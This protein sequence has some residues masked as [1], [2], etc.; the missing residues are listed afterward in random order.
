MTQEMEELIQKL[1]DLTE[2][3]F[4][5]VEADLQTI[6]EQV[7][8]ETKGGTVYTVEGL[9][10]FRQLD[11]ELTFTPDEKLAT[12]IN[13]KYAGMEPI[14]IMAGFAQQEIDVEEQ[15]EQEPSDR[16]QVTELEPSEQDEEQAEPD[17]VEADATEKE[18]I[19]AEQLEQKQPEEKEK[20]VA[21][22]ED[23]SAQDKTPSTEKVKS[24]SESTEQQQKKEKKKEKAAA[25]TAKK[26]SKPKKK[27]KPGKKKPSKKANSHQDQ[28]TTWLII[29][30][31]AVLVLAVVIWGLSRRGAPEQDSSMATQQQTE[32][33][34]Q[35]S[36]EEQEP[37]TSKQDD[38]NRRST[39][40]AQATEVETAT[41]VTNNNIDTDLPEAPV[42]NVD[43]DTPYGLR[44]IPSNQ[45][46]T[47]YTLVVYSFGRESNAT[48]QADLLSNKGYRA[49]IDYV[50]L[51]DSTERW[52]VG[53]GQF[54]DIQAAKEA[55]KAIPEPHQSNYFIKRIN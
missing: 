18:E 11:G 16:A 2:M 53:I 49:I 44:G 24:E 29:S 6:V 32:A 21:S 47:G 55:A 54:E 31:A 42:L 15:I 39:S 19:T 35:A 3:A 34:E 17:Q 7:Q 30:A 50:T 4:E 10:T 9:G 28:T 13:Y 26:K 45:G 23:G 51:N 27:F 43:Y 8:T 37:T 41:K 36:V 5:D 1:A 14:E 25:T 52:R 46:M 22:K 38:A 48:Q 33:V 40:Q 20:P 12:E